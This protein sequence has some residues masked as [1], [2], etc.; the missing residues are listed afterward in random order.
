MCEG[1]VGEVERVG[2][3]GRPW[4]FYP[5]ASEY[6]FLYRRIFL[7][8]VA[9]D[10]RILDQILRR[11]EIL[12]DKVHCLKLCLITARRNICTVC[13]DRRVCCLPKAL[14]KVSLKLS[15]LLV[16]KQKGLPNAVPRPEHA[17]R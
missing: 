11:R 17:D 14:S 12:Q 2:W 8:H 1:A 6:V 5:F 9:L 10:G 15:W 16:P 13:S 4:V 3:V 7:V